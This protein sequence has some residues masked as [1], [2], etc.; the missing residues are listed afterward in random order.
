M[1]LSSLLL[2]KYLKFDKTQPFIFITSLIAFLGIAIGVMVLCVAMAI[3][4]GISKEL[5]EKIFIMNAPLNIKTLGKN[6]IPQDLLYRLQIEFPH[7]NFSPYLQSYAMIKTEYGIFP[8]VIFGIDS[9]LEGQVNPILQ[10]TLEGK[11]IDSFSLVMGEDF[12]TSYGIQKAQKVVLFFTDLS[13][14]ALSFSPTMKRFEVKGF[15][16]SGIRAYDRGYSYT[17]L[18][19]LAKIKGIQPNLY[20]GIHINSSNPMK[21]YKDLSSFLAQNFKNRFFVEGWWHQNGNLFSA[22]EL[23]KRALFIVLLLII[24]MASLNIIS[25]LLMVVMN[26]RKEI[27]LLLSMGA[28]KAEIKKAFFGIGMTLGVGGIILGFGLGFGVM[29]FLAHFPIIS[30]PA[31]VYGTTKLPL[32][33]SWIDGVMIAIGSLI[34]VCLSSFYPAH[35]ASQVN[36]LEVLRNE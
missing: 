32:D 33:F 11:E 30:L 26:R 4:N 23:E 31:D 7:L 5:Q 20:D 16:H 36:L 13:P 35:K 12:Y 9:V 27:A 25:S 6:A 24:L 3:M 14:S 8:T 2:P 28:S 15:F 18:E 10:S 19:S 21:D 1:S 17:S 29:E 34:I 22:M